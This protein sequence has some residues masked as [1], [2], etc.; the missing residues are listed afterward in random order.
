[1][2]EQCSIMSDIF[3]QSYV[4]QRII[5][6]VQSGL[7]CHTTSANLCDAGVR[8]SLSECL[9]GSWHLVSIF[10]IRTRELVCGRTQQWPMKGVVRRTL[11]EWVVVV[12]TN[13]LRVQALQSRIAIKGV[14]STADSLCLAAL[15]LR[16]SLSCVHTRGLPAPQQCLLLYLQSP[17]LH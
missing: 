11:V 13:R 9:A 8:P 1:M 4:S 3:A 7:G 16:S 10:W 17:S 6:V 2:K 12:R 15:M 14:S 5:C